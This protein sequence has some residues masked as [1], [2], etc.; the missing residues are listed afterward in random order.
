MGRTSIVL[1]I[2][3]LCGQQS[4]G[5]SCQGNDT[6][7]QVPAAPA[8]MSNE[9]RCD[10]IVNDHSENGMCADTSVCPGP[11]CQCPG[12]G[13]NLCLPPDLNHDT[14]TDP[15]VINKL[16]D[17]NFDFDVAVTQYCAQRAQE[18]MID[19]G[20]VS[21]HGVICNGEEKL[22]F[23]VDLP[24]LIS[25]HAVGYPTATGTT[26]AETVPCDLSDC[27][28]GTE[29]TCGPGFQG[30]DCEFDSHVNLCEPGPSCTKIVDVVIPTTSTFEGPDCK[31]PCPDVL[32]VNGPPPGNCDGDNVFTLTGGLHPEACMCNQVSAQSSCDNMPSEVFCSPQPGDG[33]GSPLLTQLSRVNTAEVNAQSS[34]ARVTVHIPAESDTRTSAIHGW[35]ELYG[36]APDTDTPEQDMRLDFTLFVDDF[37]ASNRFRFTLAPDEEA[38]NIVIQGGNGETGVLARVFSNGTGVIPAGSLKLV[39]NAI[40]IE[41]PL[42]GDNTKKWHTATSTNQ[43]DVQFNIDFN[44]NTIS[45]PSF[46]INVPG[47][48]SAD[49]TINLVAAIT[50]QPPRAK[51]STGD[52]N[53][54][55]ECDVPG[56]AAVTLDASA[57]TDHDGGTLLFSWWKEFAFN[58]AGLVGGAPAVEITAPYNGHSPTETTYSVSVTDAH[59]V[60]TTSTVAITV[61]DTLGPQVT[62]ILDDNGFCKTLHPADHTITAVSLSD[63]VRVHDQCDGDLDANAAGTIIRVTSD[64]V[65]NDGGDANT[66]DDIQLQGPATV[67]LRA[68]RTGSGDGRVYTIVYELHDQSGNTTQGTVKVEVPHDNG[69]IPAIDS[70]AVYCVGA[71]CGS[72]PGS[73]CP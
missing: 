10:C 65:D 26:T 16:N 13:F 19:I 30:L 2:A 38:S 55:Y 70:G 54:V 6:S 37:T 73:N 57:S 64:E 18:I 41:H 43:Q 7:Q 68:E 46:P 15:A 47:T 9:V 72:T 35:I 5:C 31:Q 1:L 33:L 23:Q 71:N 11:N 52:G 48:A 20:A 45:I 53:T 59:F 50:N 34:S 4:A 42:I 22:G 27:L 32:C 25:C 62:P 14:A 66:C 40:Q 61:Q 17:S 24:A 63:C 67:G 58:P 3:I 44:T 8:L 39:A 12:V 36:P 29:T 21:Q 56:G 49:A 60:T 69:H 51:A 28:G